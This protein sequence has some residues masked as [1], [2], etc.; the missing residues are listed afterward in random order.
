MNAEEL[1]V[2]TMNSD[3]RTLLKVTIEDAIKAEETFTVLSGKDV[4][5]RREYIET[6]A[7]DVKNLDV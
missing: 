5:R 2:T 4:Q 6:H 1:A 3:S 7:L